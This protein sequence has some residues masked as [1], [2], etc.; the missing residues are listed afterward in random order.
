MRLE[1]V[2]QRA[3]S[4]DEVRGCRTESCVSLGEALH[5]V[6]KNHHIKGD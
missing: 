2:E 4:L 3:V 5:Y 1:A 6:R